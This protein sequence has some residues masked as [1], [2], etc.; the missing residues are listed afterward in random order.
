[1]WLQEVETIFDKFESEDGRT[2]PRLKPK[3]FL[4]KA[5]VLVNKHIFARLVKQ[6]Q[7]VVIWN[8]VRLSLIAPLRLMLC[9]ETIDHSLIAN[10]AH[11]WH[12]D[13]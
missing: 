5:N 12:K 1:M 6:S 13:L 2:L 9:I 11:Y 7:L 8:E 3:H 10:S 4:D